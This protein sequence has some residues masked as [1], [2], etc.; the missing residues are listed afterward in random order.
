M[1]TGTAEAVAKIADGLMLLTPADVTV[2][3]FATVTDPPSAF[4]TVTEYAPGVATLPKEVVPVI[5]T[6][7][8]VSTEFAETAVVTVTGILVPSTA[9]VRVM[10]GLEVF[11][12]PVPV[13]VVTTVCD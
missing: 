3:A 13:R 6:P 8:E 9:L 5:D 2:K 12:K 1:V 10:V 11:S 7:R 4:F